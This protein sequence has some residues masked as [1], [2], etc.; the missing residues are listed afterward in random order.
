MEPGLLDTVLFLRLILILC[1]HLFS[2]P[3]GIFL[4]CILNRILHEAIISPMHATCPSFLVPPDFITLII[5]SK[6]YRLWTFFSPFKCSP[7][8]ARFFTIHA[9][10]QQNIW[11]CFSHL[12]DHFIVVICNCKCLCMP[13]R[14]NN[15]ISSSDFFLFYL[16]SFPDRKISVL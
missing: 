8:I 15:C 10:Y 9:K 4:W 1:C 16:F 6:F 7:E 12:D 2:I 14:I 3:N 13:C 5:S 11:Y